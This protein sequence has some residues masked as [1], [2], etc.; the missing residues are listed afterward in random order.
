MPEPVVVAPPGLAVTV[1]LPDAGSPLSGTLPVDTL[2]V[3]W[4]TVPTTGA[5]GV[6]GWVL[7]SAVPDETEVQPTALVT[8][9]E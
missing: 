9:Q 2:Q 5:V 7:I 8:V 4:I 1:Q 3:G 6:T